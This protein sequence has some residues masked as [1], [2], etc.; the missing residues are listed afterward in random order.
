MKIIASWSSPGRLPE[1][2]LTRRIVKLSTGKLNSKTG[3]F[4]KEE[5]R[6][7]ERQQEQKIY[8]RVMSYNTNK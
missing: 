8:P 7:Q 4:V 1:Q 2:F 3:R 6:V 5:P